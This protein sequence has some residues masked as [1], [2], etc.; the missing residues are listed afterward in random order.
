MRRTDKRA[1]GRTVLFDADSNEEDEYEAKMVGRATETKKGCVMIESRSLMCW[2]EW[3]GVA[4][5]VIVR[6]ACV[7]QLSA[8]SH[9]RL[10]YSKGM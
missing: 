4:G 8:R 10:C 2:L 1:A 3:N 7:Q 6:H 5:V 9:G